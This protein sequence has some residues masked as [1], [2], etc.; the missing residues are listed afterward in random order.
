MVGGGLRHVTPPP[1]FCLCLDRLELHGQVQ[2][3]GA[4]H[5]SVVWARSSALQLL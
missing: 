5:L 4:Q 3:P 2:P 1:S